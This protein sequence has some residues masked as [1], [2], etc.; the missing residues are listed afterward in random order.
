VRFAVSFSDIG[1]GADLLHAWIRRN[2]VRIR[3]NRVFIVAFMGK[4]CSIEKGLKKIE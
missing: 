3:R 2:A 4:D 1:G